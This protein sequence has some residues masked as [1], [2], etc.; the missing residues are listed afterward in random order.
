MFTWTPPFPPLHKPTD[1]TDQQ[2]ER[3]TA[4]TQS[5]TGRRITKHAWYRRARAGPR[6]CGARMT[7]SLAGTEFFYPL[8]GSGLRVLGYKGCRSPAPSRRVRIRRENAHELVELFEGGKVFEQGTLQIVLTRC[9]VDI[10]VVHVPDPPPV[11]SLLTFSLVSSLRFP[12][13]QRT[14]RVYVGP[15]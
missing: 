2:L 12:T 4:T 15:D 9:E 8:A 1:Q 11:S 6:P 14:P 3:V 7:R 13:V 5:V 10:S